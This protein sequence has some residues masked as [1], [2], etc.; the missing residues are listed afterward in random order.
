[1]SSSPLSAD[2]PALSLHQ[3]TTSSITGQPH[4]HRPEDG[5]GRSPSPQTHGS[6]FSQQ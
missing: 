4:L 1:P 3:P 6:R 2:R 5:Q